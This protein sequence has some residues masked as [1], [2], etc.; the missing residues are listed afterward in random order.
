MIKTVQKIT[1][2]LMLSLT[3][4]SAYAAVNGCDLKRAEIEKEISYAKAHNN[5]HK[6]AGLEK[7]LKDVNTYCTHEGLVEKAQDEVKEI[8]NKISEKQAELKERQS[9]LNEAKTGE[10]RDK[11]EKYQ[12][13]IADKQEEINEL[14]D[15]LKEA[16]AEL[17]KLNG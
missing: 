15:E 13:K 7:A 8:E 10:K 2:P 12:E 1:L 5:S 14:Q 17:A 4:G 6:V 16:K 11:I 9:E 3:M